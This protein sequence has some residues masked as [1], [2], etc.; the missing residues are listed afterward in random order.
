MVVASVRTES[1]VNYAVSRLHVT[2]TR[3]APIPRSGLFV[4]TDF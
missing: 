1:V 2:L 4:L 3:P